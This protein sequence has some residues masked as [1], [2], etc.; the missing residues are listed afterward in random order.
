MI[1][2]L[3]LQNQRTIS[4]KPRFI[5]GEV[6]LPTQQRILDILRYE[7]GD[8]PFQ[9]SRISLVYQKNNYA[10]M[11]AVVNKITTKIT[12]WMANLMRGG[13]FSL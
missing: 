9:V 6:D 3:Q 12:S 11:Q 7:L 5:F 4:T 10:A 2:S 1:Y 13:G 8:F